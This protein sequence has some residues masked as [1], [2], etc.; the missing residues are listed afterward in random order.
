MCFIN[1]PAD[2]NS[3]IHM[4]KRYEQL[5]PNPDV[6][7]LNSNIGHWPQIEAPMGTLNVFYLFL[8]Q[9]KSAA[10]TRIDI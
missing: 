3:S 7:L 6:K 8:N 10:E 4:V 5:I 1:G 9:L 2:P